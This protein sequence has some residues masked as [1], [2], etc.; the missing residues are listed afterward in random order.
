MKYI[1]KNTPI[2]SCIAL[3]E[4]T[5]DYES[6]IVEIIEDALTGKSHSMVRLV[7]GGLYYVP[8]NF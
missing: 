5:F 8:T 3:G 1:K 7:D 4:K 6:S 2:T